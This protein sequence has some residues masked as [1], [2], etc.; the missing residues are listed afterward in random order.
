MGSVTFDM[1]SVVALTSACALMLVFFGLR[2]GLLRLR[3]E[4]RRCPSCGRRLR[5]WT[6]VSC[7][8]ESGG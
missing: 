5:E 8:H 1:A 3:P 6:C 7:A 4:P 2:D